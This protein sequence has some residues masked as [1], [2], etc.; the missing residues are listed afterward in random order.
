[1]PR[2]AP[3]TL[4]PPR[5]FRRPVRAPQGERTAKAD[6]EGR[7]EHIKEISQN[8]RANWFGLLALLAFVGVALLGHEDA[9]FFARGVQTTLPV[10]GIDVPT[11]SFF[12]AAGLL[13]AA[14][15]IY[16]HLYL[17]G[18]WYALAEIR[19]DEGA[20]PLSDT[21]YPGLFAQSALWWRNRSRHRR[22]HQEAPSAAPRI[23]GWLSVAISVLFGWGF[24][25]IVLAGLWWRSMPAHEPWLTLAI[26]AAF[27]GALGVGV[28][29]FAT[30]ARR[31]GRAGREQVVRGN[32]PLRSALGLAFALVALV[33]GERTG[34]AV[35]WCSG[36]CPFER[37]AF[38][39]AADLRNDAERQ[40]AEQRLL[41]PP[42]WTWNPVL[43]LDLP[44]LSL[45]PIDLR[46]AEL[47][48]RPAE[49]LPYGIWRDDLESAWRRERAIDG[50]MSLKQEK[51]FLAE[52]R[53]R[54]RLRI[55][56]LQAADLKGLDLR[57]AD[58][59][60]AF[61]PGADLRGAMLRGAEARGA[62]MPG[63][64]LECLDPARSEGETD[65]DCTDL[66]DA[67]LG[68]AHLEGAT[69]GKARIEGTNLNSAGLDV[70]EMSGVRADDATVLAG[71]SL[72]GASLTGSRL[73]GVDLSEAN[74]NRAAMESA[75]M[76]GAI[77]WDARMQKAVLWGA[78]MQGAVLTGAQMQGAV[79]WDARMQGADLTGA[80]MQGAVLRGAQMQGADCSAA[81][82]TGAALQSAMV[83]CDNL[84]QAQLEAA[85]GDA[86][87][88]VPEGMSVRSCLESLPVEV[89]AALAHH[90]A[91][92]TL[93]RPAR[94]D[95]R[96]TLLCDRDE[97]GALTER[98]HATGAW[99][100]EVRHWPEEA[101]RDLLRRQIEGMTDP[102]DW[103]QALLREIRGY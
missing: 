2:R 20:P 34:N 80:Q 11:R 37:L 35:I 3:T 73:D 31:L 79:L 1:M 10:V 88:L 16:L 5:P 62:V 64:R 18:L 70:A 14:L 78:R 60:G 17:L 54:W 55:A 92:G 38:F 48:V 15:Y 69:V 84:T 4:L 45:A 56:A 40:F 77:L 58:M 47:T 44:F 68:D 9:D 52:A 67:N 98:P 29:T 28:T 50:E 100:F 8:A 27:A 82:F 74:L 49:W 97:D 65:Q 7:L 93:G 36:A 76:Q 91:E 90:P 25:L 75:Q 63:A 6:V 99:P 87:T 42:G 57:G 22:R 61:L 85:V 21:V 102:P 66:T 43:D 81:G 86:F 51:A 24:G 33:S 23:F 96:A 19:Q 101:R 32:W 13:I 103:A 94:G 95:V 39:R 71:A 41:D 30:A 72:V 53:R 12:L 83:L 46:E 26:G 59:T 89:E